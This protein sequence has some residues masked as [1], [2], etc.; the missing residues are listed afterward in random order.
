MKNKAIKFGIIAGI[1]PHLFCCILPVVLGLVGLFAPGIADHE[2][3]PESVEKWVFI[4]SG[5][6]LVLSWFLYFSNRDCECKHCRDTKHHRIQL[7]ILIC[8]TILSLFGIISHI[9]LHH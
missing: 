8:I 6:M 9:F 5:L 7:I 2:L 3:I 4:F 1:L